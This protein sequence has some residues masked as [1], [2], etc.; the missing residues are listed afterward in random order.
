MISLTAP[1]IPE[2]GPSV[3]SPWRTIAT[4][5]NAVT[6]ARTVMAVALGLASIVNHSGEQLVA[7]YAIYW[8]GDIADGWSARLLGQETRIGAMLDILSDRACTAV[9][10][11]S[12]L[13]LEP[14]LWLPLVVFL[15][16][17]MVLDCL[18]SLS[19]LAWPLISPNY[20]DRVSPPVWAWNWSPLAKATNTAGVI[21]A[22][23]LAPTSVALITALAITAVKIVS[24]RG[25]L[26]ILPTDASHAA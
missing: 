18:L 7:A 20:F 4:I 23:V 19:F 13:A 17:F 12:L 9:L 21:G 1:N 14:D 3:L 5:P 8:I 11:C 24:I 10:T 16:Q 25:V 6:L 26:Q 15:L 22:A 2:P